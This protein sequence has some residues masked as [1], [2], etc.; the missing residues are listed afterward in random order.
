MPVGGQPTAIPS[1]RAR[2]Y[3]LDRVPIGFEWRLS[4]LWPKLLVVS[5][6]WYPGWKARVNG[7]LRPVERVNGTLMGVQVAPGAS[8]VEFVYRPTAI[9]LGVGDGLGSIRESW[10]SASS[11]SRNRIPDH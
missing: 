11:S 1:H 2:L 5:Q 6:N 9:P 4:L 8:R 10:G 3:L 7:E